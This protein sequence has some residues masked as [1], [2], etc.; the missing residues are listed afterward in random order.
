[1]TTSGQ[2]G[3]PYDHTTYEFDCTLDSFG[4]V[5]LADLLEIFKEISKLAKPPEG[6]LTLTAR[7]NYARPNVWRPFSH[8]YDTFSYHEEWGIALDSE[9]SCREF[10]NEPGAMES[11]GPLLRAN[12][13]VLRK[14]D[15]HEDR[16]E[17]PYVCLKVSFPLDRTV[18]Q[19]VAL[20]FLFDSLIANEEGAPT[21]PAGVLALMASK[22]PEALLGQPESQWLEVKQKGYGFENDRQKHEFAL[23]LAAFANCDSG[24]IIVVGLSTSRDASGQDIIT[25]ANGCSPGSLNV[26]SYAEVAKH[27]VVP[28]I[29]G[30]DIRVISS[31]DRSFLM[32]LVPPQPQQF[33]PFLVRGGVISGDRVSGAAFTIPQRV[34]SEKWNVS[35]EAVH[36]QLVAARIALSR[37]DTTGR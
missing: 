23:D 34:G 3:R 21:S 19:I 20:S 6:G 37:A 30:L 10:T 31:N 7:T 35:A 12:K 28:P 32:A 36:S 17:G 25:A 13:G 5:L 29:E 15:C 11:I 27:R 2:A 22:I 18:G 1:M 26:D 24:G 4:N 14:I 33:R 8:R 9:Y 16:G